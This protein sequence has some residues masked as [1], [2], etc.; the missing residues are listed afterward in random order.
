VK[1]HNGA[2]S[3]RQLLIGLDAA[4]WDLIKKWACE[5]KLPTFQRLMACGSHGPLATPAAQFPD[6]VWPALCTSVNPAKLEKYFYVQYDPQTMGLRHVPDEAIKRLPFWDHL[7]QAGRHVGIVDVPKFPLSR[8]LN[9]FQLANWGVHPTKSKPSSFPDSLLAEVQSRFGPHPVGDCGTVDDKPGPL[10]KLRQ[11]LLDGI[12]RRGQMIRWLMQERPW[13]VFYA[14]FSESHCGG[15]LFWRFL[16]PPSSRPLTEETEDLADTLQQ[17]YRAID[18]ELGEILALAG[19]DTFCLVFAAHGMGPLYHASWNL[20]EILDLLGYGQ[21]PKS[22]VKQPGEPRQAGVN[23]WRI[24]KMVM[25]ASL[26]Y[27]INARLPRKM[28]DEILFRWYTGGRRWKDCRAFSV[29]NNDSVGA[30]R[31]SVKGRDRHG[32]V[33]PGDEYHQVCREIADALREL[34]DVE[35]GRP[36]VKQ[37]T[38]TQKTFAG[39]FLDQLP[40]LSVL[41]EQSFPWESLYS[42]RF[43]GLRLQLQDARSGGHTAQGFMLATGPGVMAGA[44]QSNGSIYNIGPTV[45]E[46]AGLSVPPDFEG[47]PWRS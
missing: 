39:P 45:L 16:D 18:R 17:I 44:E 19:E 36:V 28:R 13:D 32:L 20:P 27:W 7:S 10:R 22:N 24:L 47:A 34:T 8:S 40:D 25:P 2:G 1:R 14:V 43:G 21:H 6:A 12:R 37:V 3:A 30:I 29:P 23:P 41:W 11:R 31:I 42:P 46:N 26:Q 38:F 5:G 9:G 35:G 15:H 4:E 33:E